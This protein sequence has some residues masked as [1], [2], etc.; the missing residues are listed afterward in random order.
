LYAAGYDRADDGEVGCGRRAGSD[1][2]RARVVSCYCAVRG[3]AAQLYRVGTFIEP[4]DDQAAIHSN[5]L[6]HPGVDRDGV[7]V[8][9]ELHPGCDRGYAQRG[10]D[11]VNA[12]LSA[13]AC[14]P[15]ERCCPETE[16]F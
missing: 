7:A 3:E 16:W 9:I 14:K 8:R 4:V 10:Q 12:A 11:Y 13:T 5:G 1:A 15:G 6:R 2:H